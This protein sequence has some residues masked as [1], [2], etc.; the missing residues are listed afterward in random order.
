MGFHSCQMVNIVDGV[1]GKHNQ[2]VSYTAAYIGLT[3]ENFQDVYYDGQDWDTLLTGN[4][5]FVDAHIWA[6]FLKCY[7]NRTRAERLVGFVS[8]VNGKT[9]G[10]DKRLKR[11]NTKSFLKLSEAAIAA[12][13]VD[14][15]TIRHILMITSPFSA[16][17][18]AQMSRTPIYRY[19]AKRLVM[20]ALDEATVTLNGPTK[21]RQVATRFNVPL[22]TVR[23]W[24]DL[25]TP[26]VM[27]QYT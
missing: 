21:T 16:R 26:N 4:T 17:I 15:T 27:A 3:W 10:I 20:E 2:V 1:R 11:I 7:F 25:V 12:E 22:D 8:H 23:Y 9:T 14:V 24:R 5:K 6:A 19:F 13:L 18:R